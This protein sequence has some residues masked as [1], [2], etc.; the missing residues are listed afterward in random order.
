MLLPP[1]PHVHMLIHIILY[2]HTN[3]EHSE[4]VMRWHIL[5]QRRRGR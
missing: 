4:R 2:H 1:Y 5:F 3:V